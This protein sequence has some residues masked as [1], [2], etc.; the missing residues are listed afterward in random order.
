MTLKSNNAEFDDYI[1]SSK[2]FEEFCTNLIMNKIY[3]LISWWQAKFIGIQLY[4]FSTN[5]FSRSVD[6]HKTTLFKT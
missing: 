5:Q 4:K 2:Y 1:M 3:I 6:K